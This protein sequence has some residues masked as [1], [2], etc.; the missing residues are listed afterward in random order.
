MVFDGADLPSKGGTEASRK[1]SRNEYRAKGMQALRMQNRAAAVEFFQRAVEVTPQMAHRVIKALRKLNVECIVAPYEAD[2]QL[3][4]LS[5]T[6]YVTAV[7][8]E[9]SDI[10]AFGA[11]VVLFKMDKEGYV[12]EFRQ[13]LLGAVTSMNLSGWEPERLTQMCIFAGCDYLKSLPGLGVKKAH[14]AIFGGAANR[15]P[16]DECFRKA[17]ARLRME[18]TTVPPDYVAE[19]ERAYLTFQ[20]QRVFDPVREAC[21]PLKPIPPERDAAAMS[22]IGAPLPDDIARAVAR[23]DMHPVTHVFYDQAEPP[24]PAPAPAPAAAPEAAPGAAVPAE[25][26]EA[27]G[28]AGDQPQATAAAV[29]GAVC[30][31]AVKGGQSKAA[32][33]LGAGVGRQSKGI[34]GYLLGS[35]RVTPHARGQFRPPRALSEA[36]GAAP[37]EPA[38][39]PLKRLKTSNPFEREAAPKNVTSRLP[40]ARPLS[41][42]PPRVASRS[43][44][45]APPRRTGFSPRI[46]AGLILQ[47]QRRTRSL[48]ATWQGRW[49]RTC[50]RRRRRRP[51][52][53]GCTHRSTRSRTAQVQAARARASR[54]P[55]APL[56]PLPPGARPLLP[57]APCARRVRAAR[58]RGAAVR[59][60]AGRLR[61]GGCG[62][63]EGCGGCGG[64]GG[65]GGGGGRRGAAAGGGA[66]GGGA[67]GRAGRAGAIP[68]RRVSGGRGRGRG[69]GAG[70]SG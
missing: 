48:V 17:I 18:G 4:Y 15:A 49:Q 26:S 1:S 5:N 9:D 7:I 54:P 27:G 32:P 31:G 19:F 2:A 58:S 44:P 41:A 33:K 59:G 46:P 51:Q 64:G 36:H 40:P 43:G 35:A 25:A 11:K 52:R 21:V 56:S 24:A 55:A 10:I 34:Q 14:A 6:G 70:E 20:H 8:S 53:Q 47:M 3:A 68:Q 57:R 42:D 50:A 30:R 16:L 69:G 45:D 66:V 22:F 62:G 37:A 13:K 60:Q 23:G 67:P 38:A 12:D 63:C 39:R 28:A 65:G 61:V 29:Q